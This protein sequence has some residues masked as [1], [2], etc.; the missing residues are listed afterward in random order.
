MMSFKGLRD[1]NLHFLQQ[2]L[3]LLQQLDDRHFTA[4]PHLSMSPVGGHVRHCLDF[5]SC[6]LNGI[7]GGQINYDARPRDPRLEVD[8]G[9][10]ALCVAQLMERLAR[11]SEE[12]Y[13]PLQVSMDN[14]QSEADLCWA[15][16]SVERELQFLRSHTVHHFA[17]ISALLHQ[18]DC[19][20]D[21]DFGVAPSTLAYRHQLVSG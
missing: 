9:Y 15:T 5:Y 19:P 20:P 4:Q 11:L 13:G 16:S 2:G 21:V 14:R 18:L 3:D 7:E 1:D 8:R 12:D 6:F 17:L 10:A